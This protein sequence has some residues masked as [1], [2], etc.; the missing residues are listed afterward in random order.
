M[1]RRAASPQPSP[2]GEGAAGIAEALSE[3]MQQRT[4]DGRYLVT[5]KVH[6]QAI[7]RILVD[8]GIY[9]DGTDY[10]GFCYYVEGMSNDKFIVCESN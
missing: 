8:R 10:R 3:L 5:R 1:K 2:R 7:F 9:S 6:W 4:P